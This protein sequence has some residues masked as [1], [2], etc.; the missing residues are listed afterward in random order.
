M[1][2]MKKL[3]MMAI[4]AGFISLGATAQTSP[5]NSA[6]GHSHKKIKKHYR[7][8]VIHHSENADRNAINVTHRTTIKTVKANDALTNKQSRDQVKQANTTHKI[9]MK[10]ETMSNKGGKKK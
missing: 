2:I 9:E 3:L 7:H 8:T 10:T 5:G 6:Y 4:F 1:T